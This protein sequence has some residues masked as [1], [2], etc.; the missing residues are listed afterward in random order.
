MAT[1]DGRNCLHGDLASTQVLN[2]QLLR[3]EQGPK[4]EGEQQGGGGDGGEEEEKRQCE[5]L[6]A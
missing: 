6:G 1:E 2:F 5:I 3:R 4:M